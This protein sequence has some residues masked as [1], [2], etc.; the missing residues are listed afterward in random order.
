ML[1]EDC[2]KVKDVLVFILVSKTSNAH[3]FDIP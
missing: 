2:F 1:G 3:S